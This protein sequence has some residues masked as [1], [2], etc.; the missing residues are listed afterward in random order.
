M[1][2]ALAGVVSRAFRADPIVS[3][4]NLLQ[5]NTV[6]FSTVT[7]VKPV[8]RLRIRTPSFLDNV[9]SAETD[10]SLTILRRN[11]AGI[12]RAELF[13][14]AVKIFLIMNKKGKNRANII[15][16]SAF[17]SGEHV[18]Y[19]RC[20]FLVLQYTSL[21]ISIWTLDGIGSK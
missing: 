11:N 16:S 10:V 3:W 4:Q 8:R 7:A 18:Q 14:L 20:L 21:L 9:R 17:V 5:T 13:L 6:D 19:V 1:H 12:P 15:S 2:P